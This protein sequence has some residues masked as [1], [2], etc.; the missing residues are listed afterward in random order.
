[1]VNHSL[2]DHI[3]KR[4]QKLIGQTRKF[5]EKHIW[6]AKISESKKGS[7]SPFKGKKHTE[8]AKEKNRLAHV[9]RSY[10]KGRVFSKVLCSNCG[11]LYATNV[12]KRHT[13]SCRDKD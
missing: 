10:N 11:K 2:K 13:I 5:K 3:D 8:I 12:I 7:S 4:R 6:A 1:M 9:G